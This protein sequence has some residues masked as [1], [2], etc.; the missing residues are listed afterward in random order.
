[1]KIGVSLTLSILIMPKSLSEFAAQLSE[2]STPW[3]GFSKNMYGDRIRHIRHAIRP[4]S[5]ETRQVPISIHTDAE[6]ISNAYH[7]KRRGREWEVES[8]DLH[9]NMMVRLFQ[10][11]KKEQNHNRADYEKFQRLVAHK[12]V[13]TLGLQS[14]FKSNS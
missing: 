12:N 2:S 6:W 7:R 11:T 13:S 5:L 10:E 4:K 8:V 3:E 14:L 1:M 9:L